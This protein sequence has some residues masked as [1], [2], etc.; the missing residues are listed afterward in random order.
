LIFKKK[1]KPLTN[2]NTK[3]K[4]QFFKKMLLAELIGALKGG[5]R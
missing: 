4:S 3:L 2:Q 5:K 1:K